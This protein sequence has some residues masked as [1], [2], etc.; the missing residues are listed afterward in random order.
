M[1]VNGNSPLLGA[2]SILLH[3]HLAIAAGSLAPDPCAS[4]RTQNAQ[5]SEQLAARDAEL[6]GL[7]SELSAARSVVESKDRRSSIGT[8]AVRGLESEA[9]VPSSHRR[10]AETDEGCL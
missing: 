3:V 10:R 9:A 6:S 5:L 8:G 1:R 7:R 4:L 2:L